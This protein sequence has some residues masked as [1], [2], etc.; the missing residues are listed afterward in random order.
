[1]RPKEMHVGLAAR[2]CHG[3]R[4]GISKNP[5]RTAVQGITDVDAFVCSGLRSGRVRGGLPSGPD[6]RPHQPRN[7]SLAIS[8]TPIRTQFGE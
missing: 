1:M 4:A 7:S 3:R 2:L 8:K 5:M 6:K